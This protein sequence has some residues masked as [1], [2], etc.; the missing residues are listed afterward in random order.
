MPEG[1]KL[2][3]GHHERGEGAFED[4]DLD[5]EVAERAQVAPLLDD[6]PDAGGFEFARIGF[7]DGYSY[8]PR[9]SPA[10]VL[11]VIIGGRPSRRRTRTV[12]PSRTAR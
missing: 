2:D 12:S 6:D 8:S 5:G 10:P 7:G 9:A 4:V 3:L 1:G 11:T